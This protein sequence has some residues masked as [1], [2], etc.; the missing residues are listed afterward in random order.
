MRSSAELNDLIPAIQRGDPRAFSELVDALSEPLFHYA[1]AIVRD[2][3]QS[4][5]LVQQAFVRLFKSRKTLRSEAGSLKGYCYRITRNLARNSLRDRQLREQRESE[6]ASMSWQKSD[7]ETEEL[8]KQAWDMAQGLSED[9][10]E[11]LMLRF[12]HGLS[13]AEVSRILGLAEGSVATRQRNALEEL[14]G[15]LRTSKALPAVVGAEQIGSALSGHPKAAFTFALPSNFKTVVEATV[16][17][18]IG[19]KAVGSLATIGIIL[20]LIGAAVGTGIIVASSGDDNE[21]V[22]SEASENSERSSTK[23]PTSTDKTN[24]GK[25]SEDDQVDSGDSEISAGVGPSISSLRSSSD[26]DQPQLAPFKTAISGVVLGSSLSGIRD[27]Q[28]IVE[29]QFAL[30]EFGEYYKF[31]SPREIIAES[32]SLKDGSFDI[33]VERDL[34][35]AIEV[36]HFNL[37]VLLKG[38]AEHESSVMWARRDDLT[39]GIEIKLF[40]SGRIFG[41]VLEADGGTLASQAGV[42]LSFLTMDGAV[43]YGNPVDVTFDAGRFQAKNL[44]PGNYKLTFKQSLSIENMVSN[45]NTLKFALRE[46]ERKGPIDFTFGQEDGLLFRL[47][48]DV[49]QRVQVYMSTPGPKIYGISLLPD[50]E[51]VYRIN[52][53]VEKLDSI[54]IYVPGFATA[55]VAVKPMKGEIV[56]LGVVE[57]QRG[58]SSVIEVKDKSGTPVANSNVKVLSLTHNLPTPYQSINIQGGSVQYRPDGALGLEILRVHSSKES[59]KISGL[60]PGEYFIQ[61]THGTYGNAIT[62]FKVSEGSAPSLI[63]VILEKPA[64]A[65]VRGRVTISGDVPTPVQLGANGKGNMLEIWMLPIDKNNPN[66]NSVPMSFKQKAFDVGPFGDYRFEEVYEGT[67][68]VVAEYKGRSVRSEVVTVTADETEKVNLNIPSGSALEGMITGKDGLPLANARIALTGK[69]M[70]DFDKIRG[71]RTTTDSQGRYAFQDIAAKS[72][73]LRL[74]D[75][76]E[77]LSPEESLRRS[78]VVQQN[79]S[80]K[81][82]FDLTA[83]GSSKIYGSALVGGE[84]LFGQALLVRPNN[85]ASMRSEKVDKNG[86]F[87]ISD[88]KPGKYYLWFVNEMMSIKVCAREVVIVQGKMADVN[89]IKNYALGSLSGNIGI[90]DASPDESLKRTG[91]F[92]SPVLE[93]PIGKD[94]LLAY[95]KISGRSEENGSF[96]IKGLVEGEYE[97]R[98]AH[99]GFTP[100]TEKINI[101]GHTHTEISLSGAAG[102]LSVSIA[103]VKGGESAGII[104]DTSIVSKLLLLT[105]TDSDGKEVK[106]SNDDRFMGFSEVSFFSHDLSSI[107]PGIYTLSLIGMHIEPFA[108]SVEIEPNKKTELDVNLQRAATIKLTVANDELDAKQIQSAKVEVFNSEMELVDLGAEIIAMV[109]VDTITAASKTLK[110]TPLTSG[111]YTVVLS[112]SGYKKSETKI[113]VNKSSIITTEITLVAE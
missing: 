59:V 49:G 87:D 11:P 22:F 75:D 65:S 8:A 105:L 82:N 28:V 77:T 89:I 40:K 57:L 104:S 56:D 110:I 62:T 21:Q 98:V 39:S 41:S 52:S 99:D 2:A 83:Q 17:A 90:S 18:S 16:M 81:H 109:G 53:L 1:S 86:K 34:P 48:E 51:N 76:G 69:N 30:D 88:V 27:A 102:S 106:L 12:A 23:I 5:E 68:V 46:G 101:A 3:S 58:L 4:Q 61:A 32:K 79:K 33:E 60:V 72:Y 93:H 13:R 111:T 36:I 29:A 97:V 54:N 26:S 84:A 73:F 78:V 71:P 35:E 100:Y 113:E 64:T 80:N 95:A 45:P 7:S 112:L 70:I 96:E 44:V 42:S 103:S 37:K 19:T 20:L 92:L 66:A 47:S 55:K 10:R 6:A 24:K 108:V 107:K 91:I 14:R 74:E 15:K 43:T 67:Y 38:Y 94:P 85:A 31:D 63:E 25:E 9:L 50:A